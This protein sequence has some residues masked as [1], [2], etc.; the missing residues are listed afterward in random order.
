MVV[1]IRGFQVVDIFDML[2]DKLRF[3]HR[4][5]DT[6]SRP[7]SLVIAKIENHE[8]PYDVYDMEDPVPFEI[9][10]Q[11]NRE[12][13]NVLG[14]CCLSLV[15]RSFKEFL[16]AF[17][18]RSNCVRESEVPKLIGKQRGEK[19]WFDS[20]QRY[21]R[22]T[23]EIEWSRSPVSPNFLEEISLARNAVWHD[24]SVWDL[25][26]KQDQKYYDRFPDSLFA[27]DWEKETWP[28]TWSES[29][30]YQPHKIDITA[31][32]L[33]LAIEAVRGF[34]SYL[35]EQWESHAQFLE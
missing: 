16:A 14:Q 18:A 28:Y 34:C 20:Y 33:K 27:D 10:W 32:K 1:R 8:E 13:L 21:F 17:V 31:D 30:P 7:F 25:T 3:V 29:L 12:S 19:S 4:F 26:V 6:V 9:E 23:Y 24:G 11:E 2:D 35:D 5:Y 15:Q 22:Q